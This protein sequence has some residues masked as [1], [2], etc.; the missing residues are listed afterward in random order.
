MGVFGVKPGEVPYLVLV[1][2]GSASCLTTNQKIALTS[3]TLCVGFVQEL[4]RGAEP[5]PVVE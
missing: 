4:G 2:D 5:V 3:H 1:E